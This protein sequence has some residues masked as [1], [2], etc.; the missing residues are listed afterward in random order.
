MNGIAKIYSEPVDYGIALKMQEAAVTECA[1]DGIPHLFVLQHPHVV[2]IG[3]DAKP[4][5]RRLDDD[6]LRR[7]GIDVH[8]ITR[9]GSF[10][11]HGPGQLIMYPVLPIE[12]MMGSPRLHIDKLQ[13]SVIDLLQIYN[14][15]SYGSQDP[16]HPGVFTDTGIKNNDKKIAAIGVEFRKVAQRRRITMH[17]AGVYVNPD[18]SYF[19]MIF[20]CG[21]KDAKLTSIEAEM[22]TTPDMGEAMQR[23]VE[24]FSKNTGI[25]FTLETILQPTS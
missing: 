11:Y 18:L 10:T 9:R 22:G 19:N 8:E 24:Q 1:A 6:D 13:Q 5:D 4:E 15:H 17:G 21:D 12:L 20:P 16:E 25:Q 2:T 14:I 23:F 3:R 7:Q